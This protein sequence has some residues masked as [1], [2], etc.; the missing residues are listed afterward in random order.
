MF[1]FSSFFSRLKIHGSIPCYSLQVGFFHE[2]EPFGVVRLSG[3]SLSSVRRDE[4]LTSNGELRLL[5]NL[6]VDA[7]LGSQRRLATCS[8]AVVWRYCTSHTSVS[9][10]TFVARL[11]KKGSGKQR[12]LKA[13]GFSEY[14][15][16]TL[17]RFP[18]S[19]ALFPLNFFPL[20]VLF[21]TL[22]SLP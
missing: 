13:L 14:H 1:D 12:E 22:R 10:R 5:L 3:N 21:S 17:P 9:L 11:L 20:A 19:L 4:M 15:L 2:D 16:P 6:A 18:L 7:T 8:I